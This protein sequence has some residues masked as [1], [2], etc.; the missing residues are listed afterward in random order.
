MSGKEKKPS[1]MNAWKSIRELSGKNMEKISR[2][3][4][5]IWM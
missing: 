1:I 5:I 3:E 2:R 4:N